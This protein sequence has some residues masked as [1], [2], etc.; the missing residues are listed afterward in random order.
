MTDRRPI[1]VRAADAADADL[2][3]RL[4]A[5]VQTLHRDARPDVFRDPDDAAL[6]AFFAAELADANCTAVVAELDGRPAGFA[7]LYLCERTGAFAVE[8]RSLH[9]DQISVEPWARRR[10]VG[11]ALVAEARRH[12]RE[13]GCGRLETSVWQ[14][15]DASLAFFA[16]EGFGCHMQR[17]EAAP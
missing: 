15:N 9:I 17:L 14:F 11:R 2:L 1:V 6:S 10:G 7:L 8:A 12:A 13:R 16:A 5:S 3:A 4:T